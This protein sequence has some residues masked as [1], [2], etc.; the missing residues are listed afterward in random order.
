MVAAYHLA[1][2][3]YNQ[4]IGSFEQGILFAKH[5]DALVDELLH[6]GYILISKM[7]KSPTDTSLQDDY[8]RLKADFLEI[9]HGEDFILQLETAYAVFSK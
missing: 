9:E 4:A 8:E 3:D 2:G 6:H 1:D 7:L 5:A